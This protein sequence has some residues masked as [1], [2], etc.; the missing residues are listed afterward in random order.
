MSW[1][2]WMQAAREAIMR[3]NAISWISFWLWATFLVTVLI[4]LR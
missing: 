4:A 2:S 3:S 1:A